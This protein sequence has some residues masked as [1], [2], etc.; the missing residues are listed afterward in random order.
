MVEIKGTW[1]PPSK[2]KLW[3]AKVTGVN[4]D[5]F[6]GKRGYVL[7]D[8]EQ[9]YYRVQ[10]YAYKNKYIIASVDATPK[11]EANVT[12]EKIK[13]FDLSEDDI[14]FMF[15]FFGNEYGAENLEGVRKKLIE[16]LELCRKK[17]KDAQ[18]AEVNFQK[19]IKEFDA[20]L[21]N[22]ASQSLSGELNRN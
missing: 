17:I 7:K 18:K 22:S 20:H 1:N 3:L 4:R 19:L 10:N 11:E 16:D 15:R 14:Y 5:K 21:K 6:C 9:D 12:F 13:G 2:K 8:K